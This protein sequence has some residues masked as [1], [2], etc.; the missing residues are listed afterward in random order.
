MADQVSPKA[1]A[2]SASKRGR[3]PAYPGIDLKRALELVTLV[4]KQ[5]RKNPAASET[6]ARHWK[7]PVTSSQFLTSLS[8]AKKF[9]LL[10]AMPQRGPHSGQVRVSDLA[11]DII[12][13]EREDSQERVAAIKRAALLPDIHSALWRKFNGE[14]PSD[15]NLRFHLIRDRGFTEAGAADFIS[16]FKRTIAFAQLVPT[17]ELSEPDRDKVAADESAPSDTMGDFMNRMIGWPQQQAPVR[18]APPQMKEIP[19]PIQ[20]AAWPV[21]KA[22]FPL[23]ESAWAQ[24]IAVLNA[25]KPGLV[26]DPKPET[27]AQPDAPKVE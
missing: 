14:L 26:Q 12:V 16:Q 3:S 5:D 18:K 23:T 11:R 24:M 20:D 7:Q 17:D 15:A 8:A 13:D 9:G 25:M 1:G 21:I 22:A 10:E 4:Y 6:V 2:P 19:I 27:P